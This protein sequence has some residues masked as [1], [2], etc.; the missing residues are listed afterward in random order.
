MNTIE[1]SYYLQEP[2]SYLDNQLCEQEGNLPEEL[3][4]SLFKNNGLV[5]ESEQQSY[6]NDIPKY[7]LV[8]ENQA[9]TFS[10]PDFCQVFTQDI[11]P[12]SCVFERTGGYISGPIAE[13]DELVP[14]SQPVNIFFYDYINGCKS[15][16]FNIIADVYL[17]LYV[18]T[19][20]NAYEIHLERELFIIMNGIVNE[21]GFSFPEQVVEYIIQ[22]L[23]K[24]KKQLVLLCD[25]L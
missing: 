9:I 21:N 14:I 2:V 7:P 13:G 1:Q 18:L 25:Y 12:A 16:F 15:S 17:P 8:L 6:N 23:F 19:N 22:R 20:P 5:F 11:F 3:S 10:N 24:E 4:F